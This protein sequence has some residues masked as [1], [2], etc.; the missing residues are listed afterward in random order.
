[1][2]T[3]A[4]EGDGLVAQGLDDEVGD[5][6]VVVGV[7]AR[8]VGVE[9]ACHLDVHAVLAAVVEEQR[10]GAALAFVVA[11]ARANRVHLAPV[12][13]RLRMDFRVAIHLAGGGL[14]DPRAGA[15]GEPQ[16]VDRAM[17]AGLGGLHRIVLIVNRRGRASQIVDLVHFDIEREGH[18]MAHQLEVRV[19]EQMGDIVLGAS[20]EVV[21]TD[22]IVAVV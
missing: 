2:S 1:L 15:L 5:H 21:E 3:I 11:R 14:K 4:V 17:H 9:D 13:F 7:H 10:L 12:A 19:I 6:A 18:I 8:A 16:H 22:D 20:E